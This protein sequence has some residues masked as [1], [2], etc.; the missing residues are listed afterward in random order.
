MNQ[1]NSRNKNLAY[2]LERTIF[3][4]HEAMLEAQKVAT[5]EAPTNYL[6]V[7]KGRP[8]SHISPNNELPKRWDTYYHKGTPQ[9]STP[10][11]RTSRF[12]RK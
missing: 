3:H 1:L 2:G 5:V 12:K 9:V 7:S 4:V 10:P 6:I 8:L 11:S